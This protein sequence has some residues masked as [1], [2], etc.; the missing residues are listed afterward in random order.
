M[1]TNDTSIE[2]DTDRRNLISISYFDILRI[3]L[4]YD[5]ISD[6]YKKQEIEKPKQI[7]AKKEKK[8]VVIKK[9][10]NTRK[11][12]ILDILKQKEKV[13]VGDIKEIIRKVSK[14]TI[15]RDF[16]DLLKQNL[17]ERIGQNNNTYYVLTK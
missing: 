6:Y 7:V 4:E 5:K 12:K 8:V 14:R 15:R 16:D 13:Q 11:K 17:V 10:L 2:N 9:P 1:T 3:E